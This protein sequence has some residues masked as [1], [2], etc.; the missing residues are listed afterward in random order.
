MPMNLREAKG[1]K[2]EHRSMVRASNQAG[3]RCTRSA[4]RRW[5]RGTLSE[6]ATRD[7]AASAKRKTR[8]WLRAVVEMETLREFIAPPT[9]PQDR[10]SLATPAAAARRGRSFE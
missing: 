7:R 5:A 2:N 1:T 8:D 9:L 6:S 3:Y 4:C 10:A